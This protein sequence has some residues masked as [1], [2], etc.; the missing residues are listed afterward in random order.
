MS[1][2]DPSSKSCSDHLIVA[3]ICICVGVAALAIAISSYIVNQPAINGRHELTGDMSIQGSLNVQ[4]ILRAGTVLQLGSTGGQLPRPGLPL[5][6]SS[7]GSR[8][9]TSLFQLV[10][11]V[12]NSPRHADTPPDGLTMLKAFFSVPDALRALDAWGSLWTG[13]AVI[14]LC[15]AEVYNVAPGERWAVSAGAESRTLR[16]VAAVGMSGL[17][18]GEETAATVLGNPIPI[19]ASVSP[20]QLQLQYK[21]VPPTRPTFYVA[22]SDLPQSPP[23]PV[24]T[25]FAS[26]ANVYSATP[27]AWV[28]GATSAKVVMV[29]PSFVVDLAGWDLEVSVPTGTTL[30]LEHLVFSSTSCTTDRVLHLVGAGEVALRGCVLDFDSCETASLRVATDCA[31]YRLEG[32]AL[33]SLLPPVGPLTSKS[34]PHFAGSAV[35]LFGNCVL[36]DVQVNVGGTMRACSMRGCTVTATGLLSLVDSV[37]VSGN[38]ERNAQL[39][40]GAGARLVHT[41]SYVYAGTAHLV[42]VMNGGDY[43]A[44]DCVLGAVGGTGE[45]LIQVLTLGTASL[46]QSCRIEWDNVVAKGF[47][48]HCQF[49]AEGRLLAAEGDVSNNPYSGSLVKVDQ[50]DAVALGVDHFPTSKDPVVQ[51]S[52]VGASIVPSVIVT[53]LA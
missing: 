20:R 50:G 37:M 13:E 21:F 33:A 39:V 17:L 6:L 10:Y 15:G 53:A 26:S 47:L 1:Q 46:G 18:P 43:A 19:P 45:S 2:D 5:R 30:V 52:S 23:V 12:D 8:V 22:N 31:A 35:G 51:T 3:S 28:E 49:G 32:C 9:E 16:L 34:V 25:T 36:A 48:M 42:I 40:S 41:Q 7:D 14:V 27:L 24:V 44:S 29:A 4:G 38:L 11:Y